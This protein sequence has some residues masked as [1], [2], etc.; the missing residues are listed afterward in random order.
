MRLQSFAQLTA[1][2]N[3]VHKDGGDIFGE[4]FMAIPPNVVSALAP[5]P[6]DEDGT[7]DRTP[8]S[9]LTPMQYPRTIPLDSDAL[10][11]FAC[12]LEGE[13]KPIAVDVIGR[14]KLDASL[15]LMAFEVL[16]TL[17]HRLKDISNRIRDLRQTC[18]DAE[19]E[20][21]TVKQLYESTAE[22]V[23]STYPEVCLL[24]YSNGWEAYVAFSDSVYPD[25]A[26]AWLARRRGYAL[27]PELASSLGSSSARDLFKPDPVSGG[28]RAAHIWIHLPTR[29]R[30][31][32]PLRARPGYQ[33]YLGEI[34]EELLVAVCW[35]WNLDHRV[36]DGTSARRGDGAH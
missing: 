27:A 20:R 14:A 16:H 24:V 23:E 33:L 31:H 8:V 9:P 28:K 13:E 15:P 18:D 26:I 29:V 21:K 11:A 3:A 22:S 30:G 17:D 34:L 1:E 32:V 7:M 35:R 4:M 36:L 6:S 19:H 5:E 25:R 10:G 2:L 12:K